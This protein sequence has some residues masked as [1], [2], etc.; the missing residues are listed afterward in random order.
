MMKIRRIFGSYIPQSSKVVF[1]QLQIVAVDWVIYFV[2][3]ELGSLSIRHAVQE[4]L[5]AAAA[6]TGTLVRKGMTE[7]KEKVSIGK[8]KVEEVFSRQIASF[9]KNA[10][11]KTAQKS[12]TLL[13]D[14][15][16]WQKVFESVSD[17]HRRFERCTVERKQNEQVI[18]EAFQCEL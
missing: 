9:E 13:M 7:T 8:T 17:C 5:I 11:K 14:I 16:R 4:Y 18:A 15:E 3:R 12:K 10:A 2:N 6:T 1:G